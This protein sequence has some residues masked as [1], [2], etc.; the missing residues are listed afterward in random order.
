MFA[1]RVSR[2]LHYHSVEFRQCLLICL[3]PAEEVVMWR[4][5][6]NSAPCANK[7]WFAS[8]EF[9]RSWCECS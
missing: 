8:N 4:R 7:S 9:E 2:V 1:A 6:K 5:C 3:N